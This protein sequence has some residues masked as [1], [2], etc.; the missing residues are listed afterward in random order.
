M[1]KSW[2][3]IKNKLDPKYIQGTDEFIEFAYLNKPLGSK[4]Y[5]PCKK[6][7]NLRFETRKG[8]R[9]H[10]IIHGFDTNYT[11]WTIHGEPINPFNGNE[12]NVNQGSNE[13]DD[14]IGLVHEA[15]GV[16]RHD[17]SFAENEIPKNTSMEPNEET[18]NFFKLLADAERE[19]YPNC[20]K[21]TT[22]SFIVRLLYIKVLNGWTDA[23]FDML[24]ELLNEAFPV[25]PRVFKPS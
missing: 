15:L 12:T 2:I 14:M 11:R 3:Y 4:V 17:G 22:L 21:F 16:P 6:C 19:L 13:K 8:I 7:V 20:K 5:C 24:I 25:T 10:I 23:S 18:K 1:D 9:D